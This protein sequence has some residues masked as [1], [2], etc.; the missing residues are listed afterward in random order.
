LVVAGVVVGIP[1]LVETTKQAVEG[2]LALLE[3]LG[4]HRQCSSTRREVLVAVVT[5]HVTSFLAS[6]GGTTRLYRE[7]ER[8][9]PSELPLQY[10]SDTE[11]RSAA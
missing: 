7:P 2:P 6:V 3:S 8:R 4:S 5:L 1:A 10:G 9:Q 11:A